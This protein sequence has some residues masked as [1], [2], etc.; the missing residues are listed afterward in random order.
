MIRRAGLLDALRFRAVA[1]LLLP[2]GRAR[3]GPVRLT[4]AVLDRLADRY[5]DA[6][7]VPGPAGPVLVP[8]GAPGVR[9]LLGARWSYGSAHLDTARRVIGEEI[10]R[11]LGARRILTRAV[12][13]NAVDR[14]ARRITLGDPAAD[15][16]EITGLYLEL[17]ALGPHALGD[18][19]GTARARHAR[20]VRDRL[21]DRVAAHLGTAAPGSLAET[22][23]GDPEPG[24]V[25]TGQVAH[26]FLAF[27]L[28]ADAA[29][30]T[31]VVLAGEPDLADRV[32]KDP[33]VARDCVGETLRLW[34]AARD[35][36]RETGRE[37]DWDG[38]VLPAGTPV[39]VPTVFGHR[40]RSA[41]AEPDAYLPDLRAPHPEAGFFPFPLGTGEDL[42]LWLTAEVVGQLVGRAGFRL[43]SAGLPVRGPLPRAL[44]PGAFRLAV[45]ER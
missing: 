28:L 20:A 22:A 6:V 38:E 27:D 39:L 18:R 25:P 15:D 30:T 40:D 24:T 32:R 41:V 26:W 42:G 13:Q 36:Y 35:L 2:H 1:R 21:A 12:F 3:G 14:I 10:G 17:R 45:S 29:L 34:P 5:G 23:A 4:V 11:L 33:D 8:L 7:W 9:R 31:L 19:T 43:L 37:L 44:D 16:T